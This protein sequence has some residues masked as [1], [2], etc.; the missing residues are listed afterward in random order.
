MSSRASGKAAS[1][2]ILRRRET[3]RLSK[4]RSRAANKA[5]GLYADAPKKSKHETDEHYMVR[6]IESEIRNK[7]KEQQR[8]VEQYDALR[9]ARGHTTRFV[10][11]G[12]YSGKPQNGE[13]TPAEAVTAVQADED[14][15]NKE[16]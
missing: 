7:Q 8:H 12:R 13:K 1:P 16:E 11:S 5:A 14:R 3:I 6:V 2:K 4:Q 10:S 15:A 9:I